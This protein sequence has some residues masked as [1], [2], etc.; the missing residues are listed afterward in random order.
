MRCDFLKQVI[1][2]E[3]VLRLWVSARVENCGEEI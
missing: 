3:S 2:S 1:W